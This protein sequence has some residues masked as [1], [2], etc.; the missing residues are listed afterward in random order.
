[1]NEDDILHIHDPWTMPYLEYEQI[2][3]EALRSRIAPAHPLFGRDI[4][5]VAL[6]RDPDA[7]SYETDDEPHL[8]VLVYHSWSDLRGPRRSRNPKTEML[9]CR[10]AIKQRIDK[11]HAEWKAQFS[12]KPN[13]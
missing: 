13:A 11:D 12:Q 2:F 3:I 7:V 9:P 10:E 5:V 8:Y 1:M 6:R 4:R